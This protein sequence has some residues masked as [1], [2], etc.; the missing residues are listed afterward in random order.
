MA[1]RPPCSVNQSEPSGPLMMSHGALSGSS[2]GNSRNVPAVVTRPIL[3]PLFS[4]NQGALSLTGTIQM[5]LLLA[6]GITYSVKTP[7]VVIRPILL[8]CASVNHKAP[9]DPLTMANGALLAVGMLYSMIGCAPW[10]GCKRA[11][12][13]QRHTGTTMRRGREP[14]RC[15]RFAKCTKSH[16]ESPYK[17]S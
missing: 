8:A 4:V 13:M 14:G 2:R 11:D 3:L 9:S 1:N 6:V 5:G 7:A 17:T 10:S 16:E 15:I 12:A